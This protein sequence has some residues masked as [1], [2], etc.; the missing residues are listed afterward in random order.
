VIFRTA[1]S[2]WF[3]YSSNRQLTADAPGQELP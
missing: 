1:K 3:S 2:G